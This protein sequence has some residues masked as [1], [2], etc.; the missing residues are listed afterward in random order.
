MLVYWWILAAFLYGI[1]VVVLI[2]YGNWETIGPKFILATICALILL[3]PFMH[4]PINYIAA[5]LIVIN[6]LLFFRRIFKPKVS[7]SPSDD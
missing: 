3:V 5:P 6:L 4:P 1:L 7:S 2:R